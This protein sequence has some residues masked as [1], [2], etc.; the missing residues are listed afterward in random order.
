MKYY[1][2][3]ATFTR[4]AADAPMVPVLRRLVSDTLTPVS[5]FHRIDSGPC[6]CL[7]ESVVGGERV[8]RYSFLTSNPFMQIEASGNQVT[9][10]SS[11]GDERFESADD[12]AVWVTVRAGTELTDFSAN[13]RAPILVSQGQGFQVINEA[14][15]APVRAPLFPDAA[16][17]AEAA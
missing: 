13:L 9:V 1:P 2:D 16:S 17:E 12:V 3:L 6:A 10:R 8:G 7:F 15:Q 5:A 11:A 4:L 14:A